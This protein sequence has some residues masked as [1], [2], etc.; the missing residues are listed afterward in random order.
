MALEP[1]GA[2]PRPLPDLHALQLLVCV[3]ET[4]SLGRA[5]ARLRISQPSASA[6]MRTLERRLGLRLLDRSTSGSRLTPAGAVVGDWA[7]SLLEQ[8]EALVE[9]A[10]A[11]RS[12]QDH[13]LLVTASLTI[14]EELMPGWLVALREEEADAHVGL[15]VTNSSGVI[16]ALRRG[17]CDLGFVEGPWVPDDLHRTVVGRDRLTVVVAPGHPWARRRRP[18]SGRELADTPLLLREPGSGSRETLEKALRPYDGV[19]V[20]VLELGSTAPLRSAVVRGLAPAVLSALAVH[21]DVDHGRLVE[22]E[23]DPAVPLRRLLHAVWLKGH[24]LPEAALRLL[25][26]A[27]SVQ[28]RPSSICSAHKGS[29]A[30]PGSSSV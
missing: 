23:V 29:S 5:A 1:S 10:A 19:A 12:R 25:R 22:V 16:E 30:L 11:L 28:E 7:R 3:A 8:A 4:G 21:E 27:R 6:R 24:E 26:V 2:H 14:A 18:L 9:G 17:S 15:T 20:P 13:R